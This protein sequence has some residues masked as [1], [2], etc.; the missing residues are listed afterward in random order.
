MSSSVYF[1]ITTAPDGTVKAATTLPG[2]QAHPHTPA[3]QLA[4]AVAFGLLKRV[5]LTFDSAKLPAVSLAQELVSPEGFAHAV[6]AEVRIAAKAVVD[7]I[8]PSTCEVP[9]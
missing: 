1:V 6:T 2:Q 9:A 8:R 5:P 4:H 3:E 7:S